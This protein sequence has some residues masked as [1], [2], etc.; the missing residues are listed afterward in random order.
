MRWRLR[1]RLTRAW[2]RHTR[3]GACW[4]GCTA[5]RSRR[6]CGRRSCPS[7]RRD[8]CS[9]WPSGWWW[10]GSGSG[11]RSAPPGTGIWRPSSLR[12]R[13]AAGRGRGASSFPATLVSVDGRRV[14]QG[15]DFTPAGELKPEA[16][17]AHLLHLDGEAAAAAGRPA[18]G[19]LLLRQVGRAQA[20]PAVARTRRSAPP[21]CSRRRPASS[22]SRPST[23]CQVAQ[24]L[25][26]NGHITYMRTDSIT[27]S[28]TAITAARQQARELYGAEY[29]PGPPRIYAS[30]VKSAQE[31]HEAIRPAG[32]Q[33]RTPARSPGCPATS[34]GCTTWSGSAPSRRR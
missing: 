4:T 16:A 17:A 31:A 15:R 13:P 11:S 3:P 10:T 9:P 32:D 25:Y 2:S 33:F 24:R 1:A 6:C 27:L 8:G 7:C 18:G 22:A 21:R 20:V 12:D 30:K 26:E 28:Q 14:A 29:M 19:R 5:T 34:C 23:R